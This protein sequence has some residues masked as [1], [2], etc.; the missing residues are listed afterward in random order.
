MPTLS[1]GGAPM[2]PSLVPAA[3]LARSVLR[4]Q[5][6]ERL[7]ALAAAGSD[8]AFEAIVAR[9]RRQ[10][11]HHCTKILG[12]TD[13]EEA[14]QDAFVRAHGALA[15]GAAI[16]DVRSGGRDRAQRRAQRAALPGQ[17]ARGFAGGAR[18]H[19]S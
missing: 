13:A 15:R 19:L 6:D 7:A 10:L 17:P 11:L 9:Y 8:A 2:N 14:V 1:R 5:S 16:R 3:R 18:A 12:H 4:T